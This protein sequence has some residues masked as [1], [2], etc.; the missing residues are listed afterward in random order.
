MR[1]FLSQVARISSLLW[2]QAELLGR[3]GRG[4][5]KGSARVHSFFRDLRALFADA[6]LR[7]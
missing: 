4:F 2:L 7:I 5:V 1:L 3:L 6:G